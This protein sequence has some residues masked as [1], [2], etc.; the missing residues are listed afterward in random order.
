M[1]AGFRKK[2]YQPKLRGTGKM[3]ICWLVRGKMLIR[4]CWL[5]SILPTSQI[6]ISKGKMLIEL[7]ANT[8]HKSIHFVVFNI[9]LINKY[10][11]VN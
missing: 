6:S 10:E 1:E 7:Q 9:V 5:V 3:L 8:D 4:K 11:A 2:I